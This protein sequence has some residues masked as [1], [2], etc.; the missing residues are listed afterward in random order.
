LKYLRIPKHLAIIMDG[1]GRWAQRRG[2]PRVYGHIRG[3]RRVKPLVR[4]ADRLGIGAVTLYAL[5]TENWSRPE[6]ELKVLWRLLKKYLIREVNELNTRNVRFRAMG[7]IE[8]LDPDIQ[9]VLRATERK[10]SKNTGLQLTFAISYGSRRELARAAQLFAQDVQAGLRKPEEMDENLMNQYLWTSE[11][12]DLQDV[13]LVIRTSGET[14]VSNFM[15]WQAAYAEF[16]FQDVCW[17][18]FT[19]ECLLRALEEYSRRDRRFG[20]VTMEAIH[21]VGGFRHFA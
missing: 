17:P 6:S 18:D 5:S 3:T 2:Y 21:G 8:R 7:E 16:I 9:A 11:L 12:G 15:L 19:P 4:E 20:A 1:N 14:R 13:D 10:L